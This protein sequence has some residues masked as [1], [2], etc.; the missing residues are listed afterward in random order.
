MIYIIR[1]I[2]GEPKIYL[3]LKNDAIVSDEVEEMECARRKVVTSTK[4]YTKIFCA[5]LLVCK[6]KPV[7][8]SDRFLLDLNE[9]FSVQLGDVPKFLTVEIIEQPKR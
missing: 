8:L 6:T 2:L 7:L 3:F 9:V 5:G 4:F 1:F